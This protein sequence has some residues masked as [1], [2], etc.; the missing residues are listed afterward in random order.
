MATTAL[1]IMQDSEGAGVD[2]LTHRRIIKARWT[3]P[4]IITGIGVSGTS[5]LTYQVGAGNAVLCRAESDGYTEAYWEG[6][7]TPA[8]A[9]GDPS[10]PRIDTVW[11]R[12]NDLQQGDPD[13]RV[14][15]GVTQGTPAASPV[16]PDAPDGCLAI[17]AMLVSAAATSTA[18]ATQTTQRE[19]A[20]PYGATLGLLGSYHDTTNGSF[21]T[22][23][24][25]KSLRCAVQVTVPTDRLLELRFTASVASGGEY[26]TDDYTNWYHAFALD[27]TEVPYSGGEVYLNN[28]T[29][30]TY[31]WTHVVEATAGVHSVAAVTAWVSGTDAPIRR[32]G[33]YESQGSGSAAKFAGT[34]PGLLLEVWDRGVAS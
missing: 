12:A 3:N 27:G 28:T 6:G 21:D 4:G 2:P 7:Q 26:G 11:L 9:V 25:S 1:G 19:F 30:E 33:T 18:K 29:C 5:G 32:A 8:V 31:T 17:A 23:R 15:V 10:N 22:T 16:A 13:N 24:M 20:I 34:F 14:Q